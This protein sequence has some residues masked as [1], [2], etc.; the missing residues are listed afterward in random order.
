MGLWVSIRHKRYKILVGVGKGL[1]G[2]SDVSAEEQRTAMAERE[3][4]L[5]FMPKM[6]T[7]RQRCAT[8]N[9][10]TDQQGIQRLIPPPHRHFGMRMRVSV[11]RRRLLLSRSGGRVRRARQEV[12]EV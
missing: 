5:E 12:Q 11:T 6:I 10:R 2:G 8:L 9:D 3:P 7:S 1:R 4:T